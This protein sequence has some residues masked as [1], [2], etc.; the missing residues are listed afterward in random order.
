MTIIVLEII[1]KGVFAVKKFISGFI[2]GALLFGGASAFA[3]STNLIGQKVQG[4]FS[5]E[6]SGQ[7]V[8]D[9]VIINGSAYA[10]VRAVAEATGTSLTVEGKKITMG[11]ST[12]VS[13]SNQGKLDELNFQRTVIVRKISEAEGGVKMYET[14][15]LPSAQQYYENYKG[16]ESE[17]Q[18]KNWLDAR[19]AEYEQRKA[20]LAELQQQLK[21]LDAQIAE[22]QK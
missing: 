1:T 17:Q 13:A 20:D 18:Y 3:A 21:E 8:S 11:D 10:P 22:L 7:K 19:N 4:I 12:T 15:Y 2:A 16:T 6:K 14:T 9:A 5:I